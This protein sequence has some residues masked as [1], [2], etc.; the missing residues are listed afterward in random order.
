MPGG[1]TIPFYITLTNDAYIFPLEADFPDLDILDSISATL[2]YQNGGGSTSRSWFWSSVTTGP[3]D[4]SNSTYSNRTTNMTELKNTWV[5]TKPYLMCRFGCSGT[6][7]HHITGV[8]VTA[9]GRST[10]PTV[11]IGD[12]I[13]KV[14]MDALRE[15]KFN[16]PTAVTQNTTIT[17][18]VGATYNSAITQNSTISAS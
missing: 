6:G 3:Y 4:S 12:P 16:V 7:T 8:T 11:A 14:Q 5:K 15:Y 1:Y 2:S 17:A 13:T 9:T 18:A 10:K